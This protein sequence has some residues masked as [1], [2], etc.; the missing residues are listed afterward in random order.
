MAVLDDHAQ[1]P[2]GSL[3]TIFQKW[4]QGTYDKWDA[5]REAFALMDA[6]EVT[7]INIMDAAHR[8]GIPPGVVHMRR[9]HHIARGQRN[10]RAL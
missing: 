1:L 5:Y 6:G 10:K 3:A 4:E 2:A 8:I 7:L 9:S